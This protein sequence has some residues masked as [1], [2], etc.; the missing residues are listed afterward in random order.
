MSRLSFG[1]LYR[2]REYAPLILRVVVG[3]LFMLHGWPKLSN[4]EGTTGF[5]GSLGIPAPGLMALF[6]GLVETVGGLALVLGAF[7]R[8]VALL[9]VADMVVA[10]LLAR[11]PGLEG[12]FPMNLIGPDAFEV[13]LLL[14]TGSLALALLGGGIWALD[15]RIFGDDE[16]L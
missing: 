11:L 6:V 4:L 1:W 5:F 12:A 8:L 10:I 7:T 15:K 16:V 14:L 9:L 13:E 2:H 3:L